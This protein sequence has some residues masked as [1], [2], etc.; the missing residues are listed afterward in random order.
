MTRPDGT[1]Y[2]LHFDR[3]YQHARHYLGLGSG[4][5]NVRVARPDAARCAGY[6]HVM[7][8]VAVTEHWL[9]VTASREWHN[10]QRMRAA[11][12]AVQQRL[13]A[14]AAAMG[15][16][17]GAARGGDQL[18]DAVARELGWHGIRCPAP[19]RSG[20]R[21]GRSAGHRRNT[22]MIGRRAYVGCVAFPL[23]LSAGTRGCMVAAADAGIR[24]W[25]RG[26]EPL[27]DG[28]YRVTEGQVCAGFAIRRGVVVECAPILR[29]GLAKWWRLAADETSD[30][31][32][33]LVVA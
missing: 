24:V 33:R 20:G 11:F 19:A 15:I 25:N 10:R 17:H 2:L 1:V 12:L 7:L 5:S 31:V 4:S 23:G 18:A 27:P 29:A 32:V 21:Y 3:P 9:L 13:G 16:V 14:P 26:D 30:V 8:V 28:L 6:D 22:R